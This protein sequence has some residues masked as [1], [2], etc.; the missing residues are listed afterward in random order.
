[1]VGSRV[2]AVL[3]LA[4]AHR[5]AAGHG[6][7][8]A[9]VSPAAPA[10]VACPS[11]GYCSGGC[12]AGYSNWDSIH[13]LLGN[14]S[15]GLKQLHS[16]VNEAVSVF[17]RFP[18]IRTDDASYTHMSVQY[19]CCLNATQ[20]E[21]VRRV[22]KR[23][24][25]PALHARYGDVVCRTASFIATVDA[26]TQ[27]TLGGWVSTVED[28]I[29]AAG[30]QVA[31]RRAQQAPFHVTLATFGPSYDNS[32]S[33]SLSLSLSLSVCISLFHHTHTHTHTHARARAV[34]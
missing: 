23:H 19:L 8:Q 6:D 11:G 22:V 14:G 34:H 9:P 17:R 21:T 10:P 13:L 18:G 29:V 27:R 25:F 15:P 28:A 4:A 1:M 2:L 20:I 16:S 30:V 31:I 3:S 24:P 12:Q 26:E 32:R 33:L 5:A 7:P